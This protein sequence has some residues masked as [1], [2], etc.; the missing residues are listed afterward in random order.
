MIPKKFYRLNQQIQA[1]KIRLIDEGGKQLGIVTREEALKRAQEEQLD[2]VEIA[3]NAKPPVAKLIDFKKFL[4]LEG[5]KRRA[6][7]KKSESHETKEIRLGPFTEEHDLN[8]KIDKAREFLRAGHKTKIVIKFSGRQMAHPEFGH[9]IIQIFL[10]NISN[11]CRIE[12]QPHFEGRLLWTLVTPGK[13]GEIETKNE[14]V[15][16]KKV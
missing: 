3:P 14:K 9:K 12:R 2:L 11:I 4:Y 6:E 8:V 15:N 7:R 5:K 16:S 10:D 1:A 13:G